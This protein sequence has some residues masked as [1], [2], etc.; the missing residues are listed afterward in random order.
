MTVTVTKD[1]QVSSPVS[2]YNSYTKRETY[3]IT[4]EPVLLEALAAAIRGAAK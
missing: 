1:T 4:I 3:T 2:A